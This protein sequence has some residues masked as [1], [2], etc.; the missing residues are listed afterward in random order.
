LEESQLLWRDLPESLIL[1]VSFSNDVEFCGGF[2][3]SKLREFDE[4]NNF[5]VA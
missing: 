3:L 2:L 1:V 4:E 5:V